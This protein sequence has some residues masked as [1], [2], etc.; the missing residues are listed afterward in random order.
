M[1]TRPRLDIISPAE[2]ASVSVNQPLVVEVRTEHNIPPK[3]FIHKDTDNPPVIMVPDMAN[4]PIGNP[5]PYKYTFTFN[6][7]RF[8]AGQ[9]YTLFVSVKHPT[10]GATGLSQGF[11]GQ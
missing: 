5:P 10:A 4:G 9:N 1:S 7:G 3:C 6:A 8:T 11:T 2:G